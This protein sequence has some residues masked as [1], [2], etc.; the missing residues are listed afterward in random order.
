MLLNFWTPVYITNFL[1]IFLFSSLVIDF[2]FI[3][4]RRKRNFHI[5]RTDGTNWKVQYRLHLCPPLIHFTCMQM[6]VETLYG[7][8]DATPPLPTLSVKNLV[9]FSPFSTLVHDSRELDVNKNYNGSILSLVSVKSIIYIRDS[10][11]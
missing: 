3:R 6:H 1:V 2:S 4:N 11:Q 5:S 8:I 10:Y 9:Q 7:E